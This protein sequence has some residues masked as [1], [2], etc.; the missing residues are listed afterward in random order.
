[1]PASTKSNITL[2]RR[3]GLWSPV[4]LSMVFIFYVSSIPGKNIP[5]LFPYQDIVFH[6]AVYSVLAFFFARALKNTSTGISAARLVI[7]SMAFACIYGITDELH[8]AFVPYRTVSGIDVL[9]DSLGGLIGGLV[10]KW[11]R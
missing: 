11:L 10:Y 6:A 5:G 1:M 7:F 2:P 4:I 3:A 8:Q 9:I